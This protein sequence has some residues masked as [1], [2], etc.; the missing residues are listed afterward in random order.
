[1]KA[2][3][4][5]ATL[6]VLVIS[7]GVLAVGYISQM[8]S[9]NKYSYALEDYY[10][11]TFYEL[12]DNI[13][14]IELNLSKGMVASSK[15]TKLEAFEHIETE[16]AS[17]ASNLSRLPITHESINE[18]TRL[19]NQLGGYS[20]YILQ[21]IKS[22]VTISE[23]DS[24]QLNTLYD[25]TIKVQQ[26]LNDFQK[27]INDDFSFVVEMLDN[28]T[29][30]SKIGTGLSSLQST[31]TGVEYPTLIYDGPFSESVKNKE[32]KGLKGTTELSKEECE[33]VIWEKVGAAYTIEKI[34]YTSNTQGNI[35]TYDYK[36]TRKDLPDMYIQMKNGI[37]ITIS[38]IVAKSNID[39]KMTLDECKT[40]AE[41]FAKILDFENMKAVWGTIINNTAYI[42]LTTYINDTIIYPEMVKVKVNILNGDIVGWEATN[43]IYNHTERTDLTP[44]ITAVKAREAIDKRLEVET[45]KICIIPREYKEDVLCYEFKCKL[46]KYTYYVYVNAKTGLE[47]NILRIVQTNDG[48]LIE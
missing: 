42:N 6:V 20:Y 41:E 26:L 45:Q 24:S 47:E 39:K 36:I 29:A 21:K 1:M 8:N 46:D 40:K 38:S 28:K 5:I 37:V 43:Y 15:T 18:T 22:D 23:T 14:D 32:V 35:S 13:N 31:A 3:A 7:V 2:R 12:T 25:Y 44:Q 27:S 34:E 30:N 17:A 4:V 48:E 10:Q 19:V 33:K 11:Q 16:C 9:N